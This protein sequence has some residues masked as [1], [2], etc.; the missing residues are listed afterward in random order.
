MPS[1][2]TVELHAKRGDIALGPDLLAL[3]DHGRDHAL[4]LSI[5]DSGPAQ[6]F[7]RLTLGQLPTVETRL[8]RILAG[9]FN[10]DSTDLDI[11][12]AGDRENA[13]ITLDLRQEAVRTD[14]DKRHG[15]RQR[16]PD[17]KLGGGAG[18]GMPQGL[19]KG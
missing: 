12:R 3:D 1:P 11:G 18:A 7:P 15:K 4:D 6:L 8:L 19:G 2:F 10:F 13:A 16:Q 5:R 14:N 9:G 17:K